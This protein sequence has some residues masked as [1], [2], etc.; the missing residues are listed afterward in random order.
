MRLYDKKGILKPAEKDPMTKYR[1]YTVPQIE[2]GIKIKLLVSIG[3]SLVKVSE[4]LEAVETNNYQLVHKLFAERLARITGEIERLNNMKNILL[5][6]MK[7]EVFLNMNSTKPTIK[8]ISSTR[9]ISKT[10]KNP[11]HIT[12]S[13]L[14]GRV[15]EQ[16]Y[17]T[18]NIESRVVVAGPPIALY[19]DIEY[20]DMDAAIE[21]AVSIRGRIKTDPG[22][23]VKELPSVKAMSTIHTGTYEHLSDSY[24]KLFSYL[25]QKGYQINGPVREI[26][27]TNPNE[28]KDEENLTEILVPIT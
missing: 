14:I 2:R 25:N 6:N 10:E 27:L 28:K 8:E 22:F 12:I 16:I 17:K 13:N 4:L 24:N 3:F 7:M 9:V 15:F 18:E 20:K 23:E 1:Y 11:I 5:G 19:H 26:Y 21:I